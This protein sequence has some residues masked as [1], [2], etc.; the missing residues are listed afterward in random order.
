MSV[1]DL[2]CGRTVGIDEQ[3]KC[4]NLGDDP[5][6]A[7]VYVS[8]QSGIKCNFMGVLLAMLCV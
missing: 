2:A 6:T 3:Y 7:G 1:R 5:M 4:V 8:R